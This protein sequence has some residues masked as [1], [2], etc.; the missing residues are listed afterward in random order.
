MYSERL[1]K[2]AKCTQTKMREAFLRE[3]H[4]D[5]D[6]F[7][8]TKRI[9][10]H[11]V[12]EYGIVTSGLSSVKK[13]PWLTLAE[14]KED[15]DLEDDHVGAPEFWSLFMF[16]YFDKYLADTEEAFDNLIFIFDKLTTTHK[17]P[18]HVNKELAKT[19][20]KIEKGIIIKKPT[21]Y[22]GDKYPSLGMDKLYDIK[23]GELVDV[24]Y[25]GWMPPEFF[26]FEKKFWRG[27]FTFDMKFKHG[28]LGAFV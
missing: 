14:F 23:T 2:F 15:N 12:G 20:G 18:G 5:P 21:C 25:T 13:E 26:D 28:H 19:S 4:L 16:A 8:N 11:A 9:L 3:E 6:L 22:L 10:Y 7:R 17:V 24:D 27:E 1:I